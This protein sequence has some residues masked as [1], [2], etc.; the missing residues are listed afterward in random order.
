M[1]EKKPV[2]QVSSALARQIIS[3]EEMKV[4]M[5]SMTVIEDEVNGGKIL[6]T[7][8][9]NNREGLMRMERHEADEPDN[10]K[11]WVNKTL[12]I[13]AASI[14]GGEFVQEDGSVTKGHRMILDLGES[15]QVSITSE[16]AIR[17]FKARLR[18]HLMD[19]PLTREH[20]IKLKLIE[21]PSKRDPKKSYQH[22]ERVE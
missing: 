22:L 18:T 11:Q 20:P 15:G 8:P 14:R 7:F 10:S 16:N 4:L 9:L 6:T 17:V 3:P 19:G 13:E 21:V 2:P 12:F 1:S 5:S